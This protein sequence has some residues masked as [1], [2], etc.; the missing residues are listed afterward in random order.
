MKGTLLTFIIDCY[1]VWAESKLYYCINIFHHS[2]VDLQ[3]DILA[4][5]EIVCDS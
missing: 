3:I 4:T 2:L 1:S 5:G